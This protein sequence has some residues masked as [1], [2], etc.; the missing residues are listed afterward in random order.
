MSGERLRWN[1]EELLSLQIVAVRIMTEDRKTS[2]VE[3]VRRAQLQVL[4][5][6]RQRDLVNVGLVPTKLRFMIENAVSAARGQGGPTKEMYE[7]A[8]ERARSAEEREKTN[9]ARLA[10]A[11][12]TINSLRTENE[13]LA[14]LPRPATP[15]DALKLLIRP[16]V[17]EFLEELRGVPGERA[18]G[19]SLE[20]LISLQNEHE[21]IEP[22]SKPRHECEP[23]QEAKKRP[24]VVLVI[25]LKPE[26]RARMESLFSGRVRFKFW[27]S[28]GTA[29]PTGIDDKAKGA[30]I[31]LCL[32]GGC[33]HPEVE[34]AMRNNDRVERVVR[35]SDEDLRM[36]IESFLKNG[37][38]SDAAKA[39]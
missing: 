38:W 39:A 27:F 12:A 10:E 5:P 19:V 15:L 24:P 26:R 4:K 33:S 3:A 1:A 20:R 37:S 17:E 35:H 34:H 22:R 28:D 25:G 29:N 8:V 6:D 14:A 31:V 36:R 23:T 2:L 32:M 9:I 30:D 18:H 16:M 21:T 13:R 11:T 7:A